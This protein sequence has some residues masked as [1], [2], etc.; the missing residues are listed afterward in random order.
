MKV[1]QGPCGRNRDDRFYTSARGRICADCRR[2]TR[3]RSSK[4]TRLQEDYGITM[5]QWER[6]L[7]YNDGKCWICDGVR[8]GKGGGPAYDTDHDH[9]RERMGM[10]TERTVRGLLCK[11][12]NR[13]LLPAAKDSIALLERAI[14]YLLNAHAIAQDILWNVA[15]PDDCSMPDSYVSP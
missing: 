2:K 1:C 7:A 12:C 4:D 3:R 6:L 10:P 8:K 5:A 13:R 15:T 11:Q 14:W 9:A